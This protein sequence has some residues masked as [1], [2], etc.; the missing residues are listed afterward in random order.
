MTQKTM[1]HEI[2]NLNVRHWLGIIG[3][4]IVGAGWGSEAD[5]ASLM[6]SIEGLLGSAMAVVS[7][8]MSIWDKRQRRA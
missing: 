8:A 7:I 3:G 6:Q 5:V 1:R 4:I 2:I